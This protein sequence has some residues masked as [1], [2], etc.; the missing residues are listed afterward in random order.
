[1][2][3]FFSVLAGP[4]PV[5]GWSVI[6][7]T[8]T[9]ALTI[10]Q[11]AGWAAAVHAIMNSRTPQ[12]ALGWAVGLSLLPLVALPLYL[13]FGQS[14][15]SGYELASTRADTPLGRRKREVRD[16]AARHRCS[17]RREFSDLTTLCEQLS[18]LPTTGGNR[19]ELLVNGER[20]FSTIFA[21]MR[22]ARHYI[23]AQFYIVKDDALGRQFQEE[24]LAARARGV[25]V[26]LLYDAVGS[27]KLPAAYTDRLVSAGV[28]VASFVTNRT[29]GV[30]F[31]INFRN[32][33]KLVIVDGEEAFTGGLNVGDE[34]MGRSPRFGPWRDTHL[35]VAGPGLLALYMGF[36][37]DWHYATGDL[38]SVPVPRPK[39]AGYSQVLSFVSGPADEMEICPVIY[40]SALR[41]ARE[42]IWIASP[43]LVPDTATR[44]ALQHAALR[45]VEV[46][47]LL[48]GMADHTLPYLTS[49]SYYP[50]LQQAGVRIFR[51]RE[52]FMHQKV[53]LVD[54]DLAMV[55]SV[56]FDHRSFILNFEHAVMACDDDFAK[57]VAAMLEADFQAAHEE[58]LQAGYAGRSFWFRLKVRVASL[59][60]PEQ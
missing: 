28:R 54:R 49:F 34:Y 35:R 15:F 17:F 23:V 39:A 31:Q 13:V 41:E 26:Y 57:A 48:P 7:V 56:N 50:A 40:L 58:D 19:L 18:E 30:R 37:E 3:P 27:K 16:M 1:M 11:I 4:V 55:G 45:G 12:A 25:E 53:L 33:R 46:R 14:R 21:S 29:L 47:I 5:L 60:A 43:Y 36:C 59:T 8:Y 20:T 32:H 22:R 2:D 10:L 44:L 9:L 51:T 42:R 52:G 38:P 6:T 24:L